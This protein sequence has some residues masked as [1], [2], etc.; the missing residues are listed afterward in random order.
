[1]DTSS[2]PPIVQAAPAGTQILSLAGP[3]AATSPGVPQDSA[4]AAAYTVACDDVS[5][6]RDVNVH[7]R[8]VAGDREAFPLSAGFPANLWPCAFWPTAPVEPAVTVSDRGPRTVMILQ[9]ERDPATTLESGQGMHD[10]DP[11]RPLPPALTVSP[12]RPRPGG[13]T[14]LDHRLRRRPPQGAADQ[15]DGEI[16]T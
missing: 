8:N 3:S 14:G 11:R 4:I 1:M 12:G 16:I 10:A 5:W 6:P 7:A 15:P 2:A 13:A 9:T